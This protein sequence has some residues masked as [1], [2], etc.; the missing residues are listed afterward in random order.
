MTT[1]TPYRPAGRPR[2]G[3]GA[4]PTD[5]SLGEL[6]SATTHDLQQ[7]FRLEIE[8]AKTELQ[9]N[10]RTGAK[11]GAFLGVGGAL[12]YLALALLAFAAA[13]GLAEVMPAGVAFLIVG[14]VVALAAVAFLV[15]GRSR[16]AAFQPGPEQTVETIKEDVQ[17][18][19]QLRS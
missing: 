9:E 12:A 11:A 18:V 6:L 8:L 14:V 15:V 3:D 5:A 7:L 13:W 2:A 16:L 19:E 4:R 10:A 17:W 1:T